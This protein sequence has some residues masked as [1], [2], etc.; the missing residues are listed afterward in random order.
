[1]FI[2]ATTFNG[3]VSGW[4]VSRGTDFVS[5]DQGVQF[6]SIHSLVWLFFQVGFRV[7]SITD[8]WLLMENSLS[9]NILFFYFFLMLGWYVLEGGG[10]LQS[11]PQ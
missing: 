10:N 2:D 1:M 6:D 11:R 4:N 5:N 8:A 9:T 7:K 3:D